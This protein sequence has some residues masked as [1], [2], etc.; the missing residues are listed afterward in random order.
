MAIIVDT[1][2][3]SYIFKMD[4]R[5]ITYEEHLFH[6]PKFISFMTLAELRRWQFQ[7]SWGENK[8]SNFQA[9]LEDFGVVYADD[10]IC[11]N[12]A[13]I[14]VESSSKGK[15]ISPSDAWIAAAALM[16]DIPLLTHNKKHFEHIAD[17]VLL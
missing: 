17:L 10:E 7:S 8:I 4:T 13:R 9:L 11:T 1:D 3:I 16:F 2:V 5:A 14:T 12:W 15:P 6:A